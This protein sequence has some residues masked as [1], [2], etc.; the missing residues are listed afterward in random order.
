MKSSLYVAGLC[1]A[2]GLGACAP[3]PVSRV[4]ATPGDTSPPSGPPEPAAEAGL[5]P[6]EGGPDAGPQVDA[7]ADLAPIAPDAPPDR[8]PPRPDAR[9]D[10]P[11]P[12]DAGPDLAPIRDAEPDTSSDG[13]RPAVLY[14]VGDTNVTGMARVLSDHLATLG[15]AVTRTADNN[16]STASANGKA[17]V[18]IS[19][20]VA[21]TMI[22]TKFRDV[23]VPVICLET[24]VLSNMRMTGGAGT[25]HGTTGNT[26]QISVIDS[27]HPLAAGLSGMVTVFT[28]AGQIEWGV[29]A[30]GAV[31]VATVATEPT[32]TVIYGYDK[33]AMMVGNVPA[34]ARRI[35]IFLDDSVSTGVVG[36]DGF[37]LLDAAVGWALNP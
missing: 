35:G 25:D 6:G 12:P 11:P 4:N 26:T 16:A 34:P 36:P 33:G 29:P 19:A 37:K 3:H 9:P 1:L 20:G 22:T 7:A 28:T 27:T 10:L 14:V 21:S 24:N 8:P 15:L 2:L 23:A 32:H 30:A 17:L 13:P 31:R 5:P 18:I